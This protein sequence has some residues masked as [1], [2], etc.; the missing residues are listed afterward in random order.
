[1]ES[2]S[3]RMNHISDFIAENTLRQFILEAYHACVYARMGWCY[4][5]RKNHVMLCFGIQSESKNHL[6]QEKLSNIFKQEE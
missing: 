6:N 5:N 1:M 4:K 2:L 3:H